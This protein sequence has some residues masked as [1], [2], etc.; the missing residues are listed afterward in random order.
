MNNY[1][2]DDTYGI[3]SHYTWNCKT[4]KGLV[5][6]SRNELEF[7]LWLCII[8]YGFGKYKFWLWK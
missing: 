2:W 3:Q 7:P 5:T 1:Y 8:I 6:V 4:R